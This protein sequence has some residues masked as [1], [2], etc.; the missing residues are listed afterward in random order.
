MR[1]KKPIVTATGKAEQEFVEIII[2]FTFYT[3]AMDFVIIINKNK[4][5]NQ[6]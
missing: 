3:F 6:D 1:G 4:E 5:E 2:I